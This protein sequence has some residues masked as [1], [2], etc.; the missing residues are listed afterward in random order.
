MKDNKTGN[1][2]CCST[3]AAA[4]RKGH[5]V[6]EETKQKIRSAQIGIEKPQS[7][8]LGHDVTVEA[9]LK[10]SETKTG[11]PVQP[12]WNIVLDELKYR[13]IER[14]AVTK[15]PVPDACRMDGERKT[16]CIRS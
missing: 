14:Y 7:G 12:D 13:N 5:V 2:Y 1:F 8:R 15:R 9:R 11:V 6:S 16:C 4:S 3:C 10:I